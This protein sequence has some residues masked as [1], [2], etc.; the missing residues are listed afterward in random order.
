ATRTRCV[1]R[2]YRPCAVQ[3]TS[4]S[5]AVPAR[6]PHHYTMRSTSR[7]KRPITER[8]SCGARAALPLLACLGCFV[9]PGVG[10]VGH[11][12][13]TPRIPAATSGA[14]VDH[15]RTWPTTTATAGS[16]LRREVVARPCGIFTGSRGSLLPSSTLFA[17][18][19]QRESSRNSNNKVESTTPAAAALRVQMVGP[20]SAAAAAAAGQRPSTTALHAAADSSSSSSSSGGVKKPR[21]RRGPGR[22]TLA[23]ARNALLVPEATKAASHAIAQAASA[24][25]AAAMEAMEREE[26]DREALDALAREQRRELRASLAQGTGPTALVSRQGIDPLPNQQEQ[27]Q[28]EPPPP[29]QQEL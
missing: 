1:W 10:F 20:P 22:K 13:R 17:S 4:R 15:H 7:R 18:A 3:A 29:L 6:P 12:P 21:R 9:Q 5:R 2:V 23:A 16:G 26:A 25:R 24:G 11:V 27:Q 8:Q 19:R 28:H 14:A